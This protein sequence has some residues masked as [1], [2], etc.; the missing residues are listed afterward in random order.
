M[1]S[2]SP[3]CYF[4]HPG[5]SC[6][7]L[8]H[9]RVSTRTH[10]DNHVRMHVRARSPV[11]PLPSRCQTSVCATFVRSR[12]LQVVVSPTLTH[13]GTRT[14]CRTSAF[15]RQAVSP[16]LAHAP[17]P[18]RAPSLNVVIT[19]PPTVNPGPRNPAHLCRTSV[20]MPQ[21]AP[22]VLPPSCRLVLLSG[23]PLAPS[24]QCPCCC[25]HKCASTRMYADHHVCMH[26]CASSLVHAHSSQR[27]RT[28][29]AVPPTHSFWTYT[30][31][32][33]REWRRYW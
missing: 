16:I 7:P 14:V 33:T 30:G 13:P 31:S 28:W 15:S 11:H 4:T 12:H 6:H 8:L 27:C 19:T 23:T 5:P 9:E 25:P 20:H 29:C 26:T 32:T 2:C 3:S 10:A 21:P 24:H 17:S 22:L 18:S 1:P